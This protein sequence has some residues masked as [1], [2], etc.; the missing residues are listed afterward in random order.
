MNELI[1][2]VRVVKMC[3]WEGPFGKLVAR[4]RALELNLVRVSSLI[5][6]LNLTLFSIVVPVSTFICLVVYDVQ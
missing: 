6:A 2:G 3:A 1:V 4:L 5:K